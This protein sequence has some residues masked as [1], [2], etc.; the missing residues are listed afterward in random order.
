MKKRFLIFTLLV[1]FFGL[2]V[3]PIQALS[4][5]RRIRLYMEDGQIYTRPVRV[6][7]PNRLITDE[8]KPRL[9]FNGKIEKGKGIKHMQA[10]SN[11]EWLEKGKGAKEG[12]QTGTLLLFNLSEKHSMS[13]F[14]A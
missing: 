9:Y 8:M 6:Y 11:Q 10:A 7:V 1:L 4:Q 13:P 14:K 12:L 3:L 5:G 2:V